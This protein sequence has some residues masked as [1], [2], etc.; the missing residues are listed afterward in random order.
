MK[1]RTLAA[2]AANLLTA[3]ALAFG[4]GAY[5]ASQHAHE[6]QHGA[7]A[8]KLNAGKKWAGDEPLRQSM[9][10]I[11]DAVDAKLPAVHRGKLSAAQYD[12]LGEEIDAQIARI[13]Q[14]CKLEP[15]ADE[16]LHGILATMIEGNETLQGKNAKAKRSAGVV[17]VVH[18]L[19]QYGRYFEHPG[20]K[21]PKGG[22]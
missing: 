18:S 21:A 14:N 7:P 12:A 19:E 1:P 16:V 3:T 22:H 2:A 15:E 8:L 13:V 17:Q 20:W 4:A 6:H 5:A 9:T 11:R 10:S